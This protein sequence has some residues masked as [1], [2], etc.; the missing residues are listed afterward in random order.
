MIV[1]TDRRRA[2]RFR[3]EQF[4]E[5]RFNRETFITATGINM[6]QYGLMAETDRLIGPG[7]LIY[8]LIELPVDGQKKFIEIE[9]VVIWSA[10]EGES[11]RTG[12]KFTDMTPE[13]KTSLENYLKSMPD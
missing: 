11:C 12:I 10:E 7:T 4:V 2:P 9:G 8:L 1:K 5:L 13:N 3:I 6:N